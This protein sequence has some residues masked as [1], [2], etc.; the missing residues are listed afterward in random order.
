[1]A[2]GGDLQRDSGKRQR[3]GCKLPT[4]VGVAKPEAADKHIEKWIQIIA[5]GRLDDVAVQ[6]RPD[7]E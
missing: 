1:M 4:A 2:C 3:D 7:A 5:K 6:R